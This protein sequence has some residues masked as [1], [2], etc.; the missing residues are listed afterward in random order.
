LEALNQVRESADSNSNYENEI[1]ARPLFSGEQTPNNN[2]DGPLAPPYQVV[3]KAVIKP[4]NLNTGM[5]LVAE[6]QHVNI[7]ILKDRLAE[8]KVFPRCNFVLDG[9]EAID[10]V[11]ALVRKTMHENLAVNSI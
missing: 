5:I 1:D 6:D 7:E 8:L 9:Q 11:K 3:R 10:R 4:R 2:I